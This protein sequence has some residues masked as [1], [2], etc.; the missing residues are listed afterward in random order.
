[1]EE[2]SQP[3]IARTACGGKLLQNVHSPRV[4]YV[5]QLETVDWNFPVTVEQAVWI[6]QIGN[7]NL[8]PSMNVKERKQVQ[9][10]LERLRIVSLAQTQV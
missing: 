2:R 9:A 3:F 8:W 6:G 1:M 4:V 5:S 10:I 7:E